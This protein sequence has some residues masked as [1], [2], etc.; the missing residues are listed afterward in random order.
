[1]KQLHLFKA[2]ALVF[3]M[4]AAGPITAQEKNRDIFDPIDPSKV[5]DLT[6]VPIGVTLLQMA[7]LELSDKKMEGQFKEDLDKLKGNMEAEIGDKGLGYLLKV[8]MYSD[9]FG[10]PVVPAGQLVFSIGVGREP[11][12]SLAEFIRRPSLQAP[13]PTGLRNES[14]YLWVKRKDGKLQAS[15]IPREFRDGLE[16]TARQEADRRNLLG[17]WQRALPI[18]GFKAIQRAEYWNEVATKYSQFLKSQENRQRV[19]AIN[20]QFN[21]AQGKFN[22]VYKNYLETEAEI[23]R[24]QLFSKTLDTISTITSVLSAADKLGAFRSTKAGPVRTDANPEANLGATIEYSKTRT[25]ELTGS[26]EEQ[27]VR[28][29]LQADQLQGLD[30]TLREIFQK[31]G[32]PIPKAEDPLPPMLKK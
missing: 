15:A 20:K 8:E 29:Q 14:Y 25:N 11:A 28:I 16:R 32:V 23:G 7:A 21:E 18:D 26:Y 9:E 3:A 2:L 1:M 31:D 30:G 6:D 24:Q 5:L 17:E 13:R 12:D 4:S 27:K 19:E 10:T 22:E